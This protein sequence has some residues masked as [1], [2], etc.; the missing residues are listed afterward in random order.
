MPFLL[1]TRKLQMVFDHDFDLITFVV[2]AWL[3]DQLRNAIE[4]KLKSEQESQQMEFVLQ[5]GV[6][7]RPTATTLFK[8]LAGVPRHIV[9]RLAAAGAGAARFAQLHCPES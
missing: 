8:Q 5:K 3:Q 1:A 7:G 2:R 9:L 6:L 4:A